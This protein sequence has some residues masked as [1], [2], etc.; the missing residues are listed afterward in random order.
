MIGTS[1]AYGLKLQRKREQIG[2]TKSNSIIDV[3]PLPGGQLFGQDPESGDHIIH[4]DLTITFTNN[5]P[6]HSFI[7]RFIKK[8]ATLHDTNIT[9]EA[10]QSWTDSQ[11]LDQ[12]LNYKGTGGI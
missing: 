1:E 6:W 3:H 4:P 8:N 11:L 10:I 5:S 12:A 9:Y 2:L 7:I